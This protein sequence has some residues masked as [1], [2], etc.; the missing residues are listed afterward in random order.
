M[1]ELIRVAAINDISGSGRCSL[2]AAMPILGAFGVQCCAL[3]TAILT[4]HTGYDVYSF[5]DYTDKMKNFTDD[6]KAYGIDFKCIYTG[7]LGSDRQ[8]D[9]AEDFFLNFKDEKTK[10]LVDPVMGDDGKIYSTYTDELCRKMKR[11]VRYA[12]VVTP[13]VTEAAILSDI[14]YTGDSITT[15]EARKMAEV[16]R[17]LG[18]DN[19]IITGI[20]RNGNAINYVYGADGEHEYSS[21]MAPVYFSGTGDV[22]ASIVCGFMATC[23]NLSDGVAFATE[24][25]RKA[26]SY[27]SDVGL[28]YLEGICFEKFLKEICLL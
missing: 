7:F 21:P 14:A 1:S 4:N 15:D 12:D 24:F 17:S 5:D 3:P 13:N 10:I 27:S 11:L 26:A 9:I 6:W 28:T 23:R 2:T 8:I 19:V 25:I 20:K 22:F 18:A 16:I